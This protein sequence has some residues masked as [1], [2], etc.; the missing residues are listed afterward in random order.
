[1]VQNAFIKRVINS[2]VVEVSLLRQEECGLHCSGACESCSQKPTN[3]ILATASNPIGA[4]PGD[5][6]EVEPSAGMNI[7]TSVIVFLMPCIGLVLGYLVG[8]GV[9]ALGEGAALGTAFAGLVLGFVP[10]FLLNRVLA[11]R[12]GPEFRILKK[13]F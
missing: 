10:A 8:Q 13:L 11:H 1:M 6:V 3:E 4:G 7:W 2:D 5:L 12:G 9:F